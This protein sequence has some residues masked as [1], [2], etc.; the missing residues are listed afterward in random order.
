MCPRGLESQT[1]FPPCTP[2]PPQTYSQDATT[3]I[4]CPYK[5]FTRGSQGG[6]DSGACK[7]LNTQ[8]QLP[9]KQ[10]YFVSF[11]VFGVS[12]A[13]VM[14]AVVEVNCGCLV[15]GDWLYLSVVGIDDLYMVMAEVFIGDLFVVMAKCDYW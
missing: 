14:M 13:F 10:L 5:T 1:G 11:T 7:G 6:A 12:C 4:D 2:C 9:I 8:L 15:F 3:C